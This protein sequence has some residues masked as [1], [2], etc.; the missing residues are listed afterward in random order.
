[1]QTAVLFTVTSKKMDGIGNARVAFCQ[2]MGRASP[3]SSNL[4]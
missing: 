3:V 1:M 2:D 4:L